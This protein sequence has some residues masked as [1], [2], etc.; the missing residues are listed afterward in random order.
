MH[1]IDIVNGNNDDDNGDDFGNDND[2][3]NDDAEGESIWMK[4]KALPL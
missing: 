4:N 1:C 3:D 2:K